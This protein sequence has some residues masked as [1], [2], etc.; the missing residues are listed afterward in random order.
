MRVEIKLVS[1]NTC[2]R[3]KLMRELALGEAKCAGAPI[4]LVEETEAERILK[5]LTVHMAMLFVR[6]EKIAQSNLKK[7]AAD[8][9]RGRVCV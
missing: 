8:D 4:K 9:S 2:R 5:Y 6:D 1:G 3:Y 7:L